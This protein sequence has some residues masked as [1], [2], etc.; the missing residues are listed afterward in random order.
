[1]DWL[2][3]RLKK[4]NIVILGI[5]DT[6]QDTYDLICAQGMDIQGF[7]IYEMSVGGLWQFLKFYV[8]K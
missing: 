3:N 4:E 2:L 5:D 7:A 8:R 6:A 1:M